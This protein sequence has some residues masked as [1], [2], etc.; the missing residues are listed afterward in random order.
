MS[1]PPDLVRRSYLKTAATCLLA[2]LLS[3]SFAVLA[4]RRLP[5]AIGLLATALSVLFA[6][7]AA[8]FATASAIVLIRHTRA[9]LGSRDLFLELNK[10]KTSA[11][12]QATGPVHAS[13]P[14]RWLAQRLLGHDLVVGDLVEIKSWAEIRATLDEQGCLEQLPFMPE[15]LPMCG[16]RA[17]VFRCMHRLFDYRKSR[18]MRHMHGTVL[19][20]DTVCDGSRHGGCEAACYTVWKS[21]WLR[22]IDPQAGPSQ[23]IT[24]GGSRVRTPRA[25]GRAARHRHSADWYEGSPVHVS[26]HPASCCVAADR[27]IERR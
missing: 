8:T 3:L 25:L 6:L 24:T 19:L 16:Q 4:M 23:A 10:S 27:K 26:A 14:R 21:P 1:V 5:P 7:G 13:R 22:R 2:F 18:R 17:Y 20:V 15:M 12:I 9:G 11:A